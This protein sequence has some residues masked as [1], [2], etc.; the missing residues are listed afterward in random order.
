M[1]VYMFK[2]EMKQNSNK[3]TDKFQLPSSEGVN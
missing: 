2:K 3:Q 1:C